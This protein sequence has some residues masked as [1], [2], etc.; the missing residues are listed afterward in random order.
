MSWELMG[1]ST[2]SMLKVLTTECS[3]LSCFLQALQSGLAQTVT[4][5]HWEQKTFLD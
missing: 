4:R 2:D 5:E 1:D 3:Q